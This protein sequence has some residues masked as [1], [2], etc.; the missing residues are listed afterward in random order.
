M[1][2]VEL[3]LYILCILDYINMSHIANH[4]VSRSNFT[5]VPIQ[6]SSPITRAAQLFIPL[7]I[8][9]LERFE[10]VGPPQVPNIGAYGYRYFKI[11]CSLLVNESTEFY[12]TN[13][14][15]YQL[16]LSW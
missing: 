6:I 9:T 16:I 11:S 14:G 5:N 12:C 4:I 1:Y 8:L 3:K 7:N 13:S 10:F 2:K 15:L